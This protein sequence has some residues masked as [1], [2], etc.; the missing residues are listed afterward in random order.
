MQQ[1]R[2]P[3]LRVWIYQKGSGSITMKRPEKRSV[4]RTSSGRY[5]GH[6]GTDQCSLVHYDL[7]MKLIILLCPAAGW[8]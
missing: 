1:R 2:P 6:K 3:S 5:G 8:P 7:T 4:L